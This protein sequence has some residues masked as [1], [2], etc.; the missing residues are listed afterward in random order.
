VHIGGE[1]ETWYHINSGAFVGQEPRDV[2]ARAI[3]WLGGYLDGIDGAIGTGPT[4]PR[5]THF[6]P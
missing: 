3:E 6:D 1:P 4:V 2:A 5:S